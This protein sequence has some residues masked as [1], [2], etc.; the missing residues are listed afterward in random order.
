MEVNE[1]VL[2]FLS[3]ENET[4]KQK[5]KALIFTLSFIYV[6]VVRIIHKNVNLQDFKKKSNCI[7]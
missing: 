6:F 5:T 2:I 7:K 3:V 4:E 1:K